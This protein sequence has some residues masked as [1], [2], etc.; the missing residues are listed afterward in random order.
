[1]QQPLY[2]VVLTFRAQPITLDIRELG[3]KYLVPYLHNFRPDHFTRKVT[4][5]PET[6]R[7]DSAL[8]G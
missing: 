1:M 2:L 4:D 8:G 3:L 6:R 5:V 7:L